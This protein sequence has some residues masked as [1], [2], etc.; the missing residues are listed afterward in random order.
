MLNMFFKLPVLKNFIPKKFPMFYVLHTYIF[1]L[2]S[3]SLSSLIY[4]LTFL[5]TEKEKL[6]HKM[7]SNKKKYLNNRKKT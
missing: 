6:S 7:K 2:Y 1:F 5:Q 4:V 3:N